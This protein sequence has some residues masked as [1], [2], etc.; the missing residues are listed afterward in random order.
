[1]ALLALLGL[2]RGDVV[3]VAGAG[4]KTTLLRAL[5]DE[6][7]SAGLRVLLTG[8]T[9]TGPEAFGELVLEAE[10]GELR[11]AV[12]AA[13]ERGG[14]A[15]VLGRRVRED[16]LEGLAP[17]RVSALRELAD[18]VLVES[19][20]A[21]RRLLKAPAEHEPVIPSC[22]TALVAVASLEALG[23][24][25]DAA[26]VHR[27]ER[28]LE[29]TGRPEGSAVDGFVM[30]GALASGYP[31][32][33]PPGGRL[34]AFLNAA[35]G[36]LAR[37]AAV[38]IAARLVPPYDAVFAG[39]ARAARAQRMPVVH[40]MVLAAGGSTRMGRPKML[41]PLDGAPLVARAVWPLLEAGLSRVVVVVGAEADGVRAALPSDPAVV[42]VANPRWQAGMASS[43]R[44][45][46]A[47]CAP[48]DA[49]VVA[50]GDQPS[51]TGAVVTRLLAAASGGPLVVSTHEDRVVHP[52]LFGRELFAELEALEGD[53]GARE[54]VRRHLARAVR[55]AGEAPRDL[56]TPDDY[57]DALEGRPAR[58]GEGL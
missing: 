17:D 50:L 36:E 31:A 21:R 53:V 37:A 44:V 23:R 24:P 2:G 9:H 11:A 43:L 25:L 52:I 22:A 42:A 19:D 39:S 30:A 12:K 48:A 16:K 58:A 14:A 51:V 55:V 45:G 15:T 8:T 57:R 7:R 27:L 10:A 5:A 20:G 35:E 34:L 1:M 49:V 46:L 29:A 28:V 4:G 26:T 32:R 6:G 54:V 40:G 33:R 3:A 38:T 56:D 47:A 13:L 18:L 41:L